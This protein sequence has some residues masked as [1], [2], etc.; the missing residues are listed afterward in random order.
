MI[1]LATVWL[2][3]L[4]ISALD[5]ATSNPVGLHR[6]G[7]LD[8]DPEQRNLIHTL[9]LAYFDHIPPGTQDIARAIAEFHGPAPIPAI[10]SVLGREVTAGHLVD[11]LQPNLVWSI[12]IGGTPHFVMLPIV[13]EELRLQRLPTRPT[14][15]A[16]SHG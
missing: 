5:W 3:T 1:E 11:L 10:S 4:P 12:D 2:G 6:H 14:A 7:P 15:S 13:A 8:L 16:T 9:Q